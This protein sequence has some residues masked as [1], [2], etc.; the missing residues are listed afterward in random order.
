MHSGA[1][2]R[3]RRR[4]LWV[5]AGLLAAGVIFALGVALGQSLEDNP[6]PSPA[7]TTIERTL[8]VPTAP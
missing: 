3:R 4:V 7:S 2:P 6:D 8:T 5:V 1:R